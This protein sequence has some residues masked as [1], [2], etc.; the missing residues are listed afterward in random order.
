MPTDPLL[1]GAYVTG[2]VTILGAFFKGTR[3]LVRTFTA[4]I[5]TVHRNS[6]KTDRV[7]KELN[8]DTEGK[9]KLDSINDKADGNYKRMQ[10]MYE[11]MQI[12]QEA[13]EKQIAQLMAVIGAIRPVLDTNGVRHDVKTRLADAE[14]IGEAIKSPDRRP[15]PN[16]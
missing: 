4:L 9:S 7:I 15:D 5:A 16:L 11:K 10:E 14:E 3:D 2:A 8:I 13:S 12:K 6:E 1:I